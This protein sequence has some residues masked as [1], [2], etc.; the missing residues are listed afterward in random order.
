MYCARLRTCGQEEHR[1]VQSTIIRYAISTSAGFPSTFRSKT[2][3]RT[4]E[5][6]CIT[7]LAGRWAEW[8]GVEEAERR[9]RRR[10]E[11]EGGEREKGVG[12]GVGCRVEA[13]AE[14]LDRNCDTAWRRIPSEAPP[15]AFQGKHVSTQRSFWRCCKA[16]VCH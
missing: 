7:D 10:R 3:R 8:V 15:L 16:Q 2:G 6:E 12:C 13:S 14:R 5:E 11:R 4:E 1:G 9:E